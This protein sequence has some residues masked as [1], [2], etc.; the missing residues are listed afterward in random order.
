MDS[1]TTFVVAHIGQA[2]A[3]L[4]ESRQV[5]GLVAALLAALLAGRL[6]WYGTDRILARRERADD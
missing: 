3:L 6:G 5:I 1:L 4:M 2:D